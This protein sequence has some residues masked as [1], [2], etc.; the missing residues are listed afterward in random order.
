MVSKKINRDYSF[1]ALKGFLILLVIMGHAI[2]LSTDVGGWSLNPLF[3]V[4]YTFH[5]PL[6]I[7]IS[8]Y[9]SMSIFRKSIWYIVTN[10]FKRLLLPSILFS[11]VICIIYFSSSVIDNDSLIRKVYKCYKTYWYLINIFSLSII[12]RLALKNKYT[13]MAFLA[14]YALLLVFYDHL[15]SYFLKDCQII[16]MTPIFGLGLM[17]KKYKEQVSKIMLKIK[18]RF[19][20]LIGV[21]VWLCLIRYC[22]GW[23]IIKYPITIRI[24]DGICCSFIVFYLF[25][26]WY[27]KTKDTVIKNWLVVTGQ[28]SLTLYL[29][30]V[31]VIKFLMWNAYIPEFSYVTMSI[32]SAILYLISLLYII[33]VKKVVQEKYLYVFGI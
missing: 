24:A 14:A 10:K 8:G 11:S 23:D 12:Y 15:P 25:R 33:T 31:V 18:M 21:T 32:L 4:I 9:F 19:L 7:F 28:Q 22:F 27:A 29:V 16:R 26:I 20:I 1:D 5:M 2:Q 3:M 30:H 13:S 6:F 17:V